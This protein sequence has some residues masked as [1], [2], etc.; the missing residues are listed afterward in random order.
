[1]APAGV[2]GVAGIAL[3]TAVSQALTQTRGWLVLIDALRYE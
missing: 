1:V 2:G 3:G